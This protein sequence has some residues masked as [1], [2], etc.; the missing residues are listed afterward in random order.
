ML[1]GWPSY[2][3]YSG[4]KLHVTPPVVLDIAGRV[5]LVFVLDDVDTVVN[6]LERLLLFLGSPVLLLD[7][8]SQFGKSSELQR[9]KP[10]GW[11]LRELP[12][13][14]TVTGNELP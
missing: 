7:S 2:P 13:D 8:L 9:H 3:Q 11:L 4:R 1:L 5:Q 14:D 10:F 6:F 12:H